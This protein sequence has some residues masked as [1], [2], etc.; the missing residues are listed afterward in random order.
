MLDGCKK[1]WQRK[2]IKK[3][4]YLYNPRVLVLLS[5][6]LY[7]FLLKMDVSTGRDWDLQQYKNKDRNFRNQL[8]RR[9]TQFSPISLSEDGVRATN[10]AP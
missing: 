5:L 10:N 4:D 8:F 2:S 9:P 6:L 7:I 3:E 1:I